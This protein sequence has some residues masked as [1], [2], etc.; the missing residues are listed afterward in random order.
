L[1]SFEKEEG[2]RGDIYD[3]KESAHHREVAQLLNI[4]RST[5]SR[6]SIRGFFRPKEPD[7]GE[8]LIS[9][10]SLTTRGAV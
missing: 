8:R 1:I 9:R 6:K 7:H 10:E 2:K 5:V 4:S 3:D